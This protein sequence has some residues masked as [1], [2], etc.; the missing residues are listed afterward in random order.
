M[1]YAAAVTLILLGTTAMAQEIRTLTFSEAINIALEN[2][3]SLGRETNRLDVFQVDKSTSYAR[4]AP[5]V[6]K[7]AERMLGKMQLVG[8][9][10]LWFFA[11]LLTASASVLG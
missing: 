10:M 2:N 8:D 11:V 3:I 1:R 5:V 7:D 4:M 9:E 6:A